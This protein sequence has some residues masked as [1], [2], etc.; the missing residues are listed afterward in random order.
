MKTGFIE[1]RWILFPRGTIF[2]KG[3]MKTKN[4]AMERR[5]PFQVF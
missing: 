3:R 1:A 5:E 2:P 4:M